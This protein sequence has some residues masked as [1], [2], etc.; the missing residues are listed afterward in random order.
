MFKGSEIENAHH[1]S[2]SIWKLVLKGIIFPSLCPFIDSFFYI[3]FIPPVSHFFFFL[4]YLASSFL[5][6]FTSFIVFISKNFWFQ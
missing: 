2:P 5:F 4:L 3:S 6:S 1:F